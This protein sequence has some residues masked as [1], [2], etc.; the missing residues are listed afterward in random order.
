MGYAI[1]PVA[2]GVRGFQGQRANAEFKICPP[3]TKHE[4]GFV[5]SNDGYAIIADWWGIHGLTK[6]SFTRDLNQQ[7]ALLTTIATL[8]SRGFEVAEQLKDET[9]ALRVVLRRSAGM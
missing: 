9:G 5:P 2:N 6:T 8:E 1:E 3:K 7:Y 4:I